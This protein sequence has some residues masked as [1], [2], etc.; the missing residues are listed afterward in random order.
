MMIGDALM[1]SLIVQSIQLTVLAVTIGVIVRG[2]LGRRPHLA[3]A[4]WLVV[5]AKCIVPPVWASPVG[6]FSW[7]GTRRPTLVRMTTPL[8]GAETNRLEQMPSAAT[9]DGLTTRKMLETS[10]AAAANEAAPSVRELF[11]KIAVGVWILGM[12]IAMGVNLVRVRILC[13]RLSRG[14]PP[15]ARLAAIVKE[16]SH[17]MGLANPPRV[18]VTGDFGPGV[19]GTFRPTVVM[20][21]RLLRA[22]YSTL[23]PVVGHELAHVRRGDSLVAAIQRLVA[24]IYWFHPAVWWANSR[25]TAAREQCCDQETVA[26]LG[27]EPE[28]Y[29]QSLLNVASRQGLLLGVNTMHL[30]RSRLE[31]LMDRG[32]R[33]H[34]KA[35]WW[36]WVAAALVALLVLPGAGLLSNQ[37]AMGADPPSMKTNTAFRGV[38]L[39]LKNVTDLV[40]AKA[41]VDKIAATGADTILLD[42]PIYQRDASSNSV[43]PD[44]GGTISLD[45][46]GKLIDYSRS[47]KL[48]VGID[49]ILLLEQPGAN[50]WRGIIKPP[51]WAEWFESYRDMIDKVADLSEAHDVELLVVGSELVSAEDPAHLDEWTT[52][53]KS[54]RSRF[55]GKLTY[56]ANWDRYQFTPF[57]D[58]LDLIGMNSYW[59]LGKDEKVSVEQIDQNWKPVHET[60]DKFAATS[61]KPVILLEMGWSSLANAA[62]EPWNYTGADVPADPDLQRRLYQSFFDTWYGDPKLAGFMVWE[63]PAG[64]PAER[65]YTP[66]GKPAEA[67]LRSNFARKGWMFE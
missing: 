48:R 41:A 29:A 60:L 26:G 35:P 15:D 3:H 45:K 18:I 17:G 55:K 34:G 21:R 9:G 56:C 2:C 24:G 38:V 37:P 54:V 63:W 50:E 30:T 51:S 33:F 52:T 44:G 61:K 58:Q 20:P 11:C 42:L 8:P 40:P 43:H 16:I 7:I 27:L 19:I 59:S 31:L 67:V 22:D 32:V 36:S 64:P 47:K 14:Q 1:Q 12:L 46:L 53:I 5:I 49:P 23:R 39:Y 25:L 6:L 62:R 4:L 28:Q 10:Q 57:W 13:H 65:G 66:E